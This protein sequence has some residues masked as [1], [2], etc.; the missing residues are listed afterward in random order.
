MSNLVPLQM[1]QRIRSI[2]IDRADV[3][4]NVRGRAFLIDPNPRA[5]YLAFD[6]DRAKTV[7]VDQ[8]FAIN[9]CMN[10]R[11]YYLFLLGRLDTDSRGRVI[12]DTVT[13]QYL[14]I[15]DKNYLEYCD[16]LEEIEHCGSVVLKKVST[17]GSK[18]S[19]VKLIPSK[20]EIDS[21]ITDKYANIDLEALWQMVE[22]SVGITMDQYED[23]LASEEESKET[24]RAE[25]GFASRS[26]SQ[27]QIQQRQ[28][29]KA[30]TSAKPQPVE[31]EAIPEVEDTDFDDVGDFDDAFDS[32]A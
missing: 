29:P 5:C 1:G 17:A 6:S 27:K 28:A 2:S 10:P 20:E 18:F 11:C 12:G 24:R 26:Q 19:F 14:R 32:E 22:M 13:V 7:F 25:R 8:E 21:E 15:S 9:H 3:A 30:I 31:S 4:E 23:L 16:A